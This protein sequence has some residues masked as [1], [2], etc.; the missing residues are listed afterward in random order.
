MQNFDH[1]YLISIDGNSFVARLPKFLQSGSL[2]FRAGMFDEWFEE[3]M[4]E[5]VH[6]VRVALDYSDLFEK[7]QWAKDHDEEARKI[8]LQGRYFGVNHIRTQD[9]EC[10]LYRLLLEY[11]AIQEL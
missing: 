6:Y 1:K 4:Q 2:I 5:G 3:W 11:A 8:G 7:I 10:Y 9:M